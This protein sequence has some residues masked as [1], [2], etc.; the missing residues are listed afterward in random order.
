MTKVINEWSNELLIEAINTLD[1]T[2]QAEA[3]KKI[4]DINQY[5][6]KTNFFV[7][8]L[9]YSSNQV[10]ISVY[11]EKKSILALNDSSVKYPKHLSLILII[12]V[13]ILSY[14]IILLNA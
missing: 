3:Y 5:F 12:L 10:G 4:Y 8:T 6:E 13:I 9:I 7:Q 11:P 1:N 2:Y 14:I